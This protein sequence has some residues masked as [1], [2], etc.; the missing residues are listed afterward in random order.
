[1]FTATTTGNYIRV[2]D[3]KTGV[4]KKMIR[5]T[6]K[7]I[8]GPVMS[9]DEMSITVRVNPSLTFALIYKLPSGVL[10]RKLRV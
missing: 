10:K 7:L 3:V 8:Q 1:M 6:G 4:T 5:F 9:S 2:I